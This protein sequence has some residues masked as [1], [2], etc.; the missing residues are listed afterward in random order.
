LH[1]IGYSGNRSACSQKALAL[2]LAV[3]GIH[4]VV[5]F[6]VSRRQREIGVR[7]ALGAQRDG[8]VRMIVKEVLKPVGAGVALGAI[9]ALALA[10]AFSRFIAG[11]LYGTQAADPVNLIACAAIMLAAAALAAWLPARRAASINPNEALRNE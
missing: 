9:G 3:I 2:A 4:G 8:M 1:N 11:M 10:L 7:M 6:S 5:P